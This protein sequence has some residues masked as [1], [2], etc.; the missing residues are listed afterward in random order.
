[1]AAA[2]LLLEQLQ[3]SSLS[4]VSSTGLVEEALS[5][6]TVDLLKVLYDLNNVLHT[7]VA[8]F[9]DEVEATHREVTQNFTYRC[10]LPVQVIIDRSAY[11]KGIAEAFAQ[12]TKQANNPGKLKRVFAEIT[13]H[14]DNVYQKFLDVKFDIICYAIDHDDEIPPRKK[15]RPKEEEM[16]LHTPRAE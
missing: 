16:V 3:K 6:T 12:I 13:R 14:T 8:T 15:P 5:E 1:M 11:L 2:L 9:H 10:L 4:A 7:L